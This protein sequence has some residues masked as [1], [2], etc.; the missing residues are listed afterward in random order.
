MPWVSY[1]HSK[2]FLSTPMPDRFVM[3]IRFG[4]YD[5][6]LFWYPLNRKPKP[7][8]TKGEVRRLREEGFKKP[9]ELLQSGLPEAPEN[10]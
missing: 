3:P 1:A 6:G 4:N 10:F 7:L 2:Q 5:S 8:T 9:S